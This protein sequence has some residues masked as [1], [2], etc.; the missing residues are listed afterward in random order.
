[1][2][3]NSF[4]QQR[5]PAFSPTSGQA[6][7]SSRRSAFQEVQMTASDSQPP[8]G[9]EPAAADIVSGFAAQPSP[10]L[11]LQEA[12]GEP[13]G[14][15]TQGAVAGWPGRSLIS[16]HPIILR[17]LPPSADSPPTQTQLNRLYRSLNQR[18][19]AILQALYDYRYLNTL[20]VKD[21]FFPS[22]RSCQMRLQA[23]RDHGLIYRWLL[24]ETPGV[25]R[26]HSVILVSPRGARVLANWRGDEP[27]AYVDRSH[28]ARDH[29]WHAI[30]DLEANQ[31]FVGL[32]SEGR[33]RADQGLLVWFGEEHVRAERRRAAHQDKRPIPTP[34][35][36]GIYLVAGA[37][38]I[39]DLEWDRATE[40]LD[41]VREKIRSYVGYFEHYRDAEQHHVLFVVPSHHRE[42]KLRHTIWYQ[43][44]RFR[45][46]SC[47]K[48]LDYYVSPGSG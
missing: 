23:L 13:S 45:S 46:D 22:I 26:R 27:R 28:D 34:D 47:C 17:D 11:A 32:A 6:L 14:S 20:Q 44:P 39:F 42:D 29:C 21:L 35:G 2:T 37:R 48:L 40:S 15:G 4:R 7:L 8:K 24:I 10:R 41:R 36:T 1:M 9:R 3:D 30:H 25:R 38:I 43:R 16:T 33:D 12:K 31:F 18:D 5:R 19:L